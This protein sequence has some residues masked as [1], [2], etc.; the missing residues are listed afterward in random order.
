MLLRYVVEFPLVILLWLREVFDSLRPF[1]PGPVITR[2]AV[3]EYFESAT[4][5]L[6][7]KPWDQIF[8]PYKCAPSSMQSF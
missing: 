8:L 1:L 6:G 7:M 3:S 5:N 2:A 4:R